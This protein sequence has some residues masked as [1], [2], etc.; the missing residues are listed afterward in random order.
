[1]GF[2]ENVVHLLFMDVLFF[3]VLSLNTKIFNCEHQER[4]LMCNN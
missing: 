1:M 4:E 2:F 3:A